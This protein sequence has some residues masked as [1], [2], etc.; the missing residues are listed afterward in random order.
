VD[1]VP[2]DAGVLRGANDT[3]RVPSRRD[4]IMLGQAET[5]NGLLSR[6]K[7]REGARTLRGMTRRQAA[8]VVDQRLEAC[9][10]PPVEALRGFRVAGEP[11][12]LH[13]VSGGGFRSARCFAARS[14]PMCRYCSPVSRLFPAGSF[15]YARE[16]E[17]APAQ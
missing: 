1:Y 9:F 6:K 8:R 12:S 14:A 10:P 3:D 16:H 17:R 15:G 2:I 5:Q 13:N 7:P 11:A 4:Q